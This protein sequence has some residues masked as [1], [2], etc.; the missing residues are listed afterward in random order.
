[1]REYWVYIL[2]NLHRTLYIGVTSDLHARLFEHKNALTDGFTARYGIDQLVYCESTAD[3]QE[4]LAREKQ[5]KGW[6]R[7]RKIALIE[8]GNPR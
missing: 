1:M 7:R 5:L 6:L 3:I 8:S 4:A 2:G